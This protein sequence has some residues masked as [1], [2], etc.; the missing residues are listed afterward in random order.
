MKSRSFLRR[1]RSE[2]ASTSLIPAKV[3]GGAA[4]R[5][6]RYGQASVLED[7][8]TP[9]GPY[10]LALMSRSG[11]WRGPLPD[12]STAVAWQRPDGAVAIRAE[13]GEGLIRARFML[14]LDDDTA[15]F[16]ERFARD[17]LLGVT[18]RTLV[19]YRPLRLA[20]V[21]HAAL[22]A[23]CGQLVESSRAAAVE[24]SVLRHLGAAV[25]TRDALS[26]LSP[27]ELRRHGL[28]ISRA[29]T[30][31]RLLR[32][33]DL[34]R[35]R[36]HDTGVVLQRLGRERGIGPWSVGVIALEGLGRYDH[37]LV[38][39]LGL[40]KLLSALRGRWVAPEETA[41]LLAPYEEW[42][43]LAGQL[44]MLGWSRGLIPGADPDLGRRTRLRTK[45]AA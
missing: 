23:M 22:R 42:Q 4:N 9:N 16:H 33:L 18:A 19:G 8:V 39:D 2:T 31:V 3:P 40:V 37:G 25:A 35:L 7:L 24:R 20:T 27:A 26:R 14:A 12:G 28:A 34:E 43:G 1:E 15:G 21:A 36:D 44:L 13:S 45:R 5:P 32:S 6:A 10:R 30:L 11:V 38:G 41:E 17:P 29:T